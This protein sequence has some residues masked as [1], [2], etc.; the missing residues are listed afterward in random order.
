MGTPQVIEIL[1][2]NGADVNRTDKNGR[3]PLFAAIFARRLSIIKTLI[4]AGA[5]V[6]HT[7]NT[8][9]TAFHYAALS[10]NKWSANILLKNGALVYIKDKSLIYSDVEKAIEDYLVSIDMKDVN[11][12]LLDR[13]RIYPHY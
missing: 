4:D 8:S 6:N 9:H 7:D 2:N 5:D 3:T 11:K 10:G 12:N 1:I 13:L